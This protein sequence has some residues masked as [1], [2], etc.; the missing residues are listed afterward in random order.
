MPIQITLIEHIHE[1]LGCLHHKSGEIF[2]IYSSV[3]IFKFKLFL[4]ILEKK[5]TNL[6]IVDFEIRCAD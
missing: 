2:N 3:L 1:I 6:F 5:I 4:A